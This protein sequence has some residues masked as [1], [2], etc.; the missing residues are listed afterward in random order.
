[1]TTS[2]EEITSP[3]DRSTETTGHEWD[4]IKEFN[5]PLP[6]WWL[7]TFYATILWALA[8][9]VAFPSWPLLKQATS[10]VIGYSSR[11]AL[12]SDLERYRLANAPF[13]AALVT[14][15]L[16]AIAASPELA[17]YAGSGGGALF[18]THCAQCHGSGAA[19][20]KGYPNLLDDDWIWGGSIADI[21]LTIQ[22]GIRDASD[23]DTRDSQMLAFGELLE[24][25]EIADVRHFVLS[26]SGAGHNPSLVTSGSRVFADNCASCH[27]ETGAGDREFGAPDLTDS[28]WL[29]G[30]D[31]QGV[32][33]TIVNGRNGMMP[34]WQNRLSESQI[35][36]LAFYVHQLG[37]GE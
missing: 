7:W 20:A 36:Q 24:P 25:E 5:N 10:G 1:M 12:E 33:E 30:G 32:A 29:Y 35:R 28:I 18:R 27:G 23:P 19:G 15:D 34:A 21:Y 8:Y 22:H 26:L 14:T 37:G 6:R 13:D 9:M 17:Q 31:Q 2:K 11:V 16:A 3:Q 4:G